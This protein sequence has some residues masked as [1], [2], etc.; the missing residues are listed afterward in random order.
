MDIQNEIQKILESH[1]Q[2]LRTD[3]YYG[4]VIKESQVDD[5]AVEIANFISSNLRVMRSVCEHEY[6]DYGNGLDV[7]KKC[8]DWKWGE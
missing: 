8:N 7:C 2:E 4:N 3:T 6:L 5:V 1:I